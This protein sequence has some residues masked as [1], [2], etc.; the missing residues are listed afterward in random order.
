MNI[1]PLNI[2]TIRR[3]FP[4]LIAHEIVGI[5]PMAGPVGFAFALKY[6]FLSTKN[7]NEFMKKIRSN[8]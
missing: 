6:Q 2:P 4:E 7:V 3:V 1:P 8:L 5:Q